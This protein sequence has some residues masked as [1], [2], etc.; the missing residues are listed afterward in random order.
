MMNKPERF[1]I[2]D[3]IFNSNQDPDHNAIE[4]PGYQPLTYRELRI[5]ILCVIKTLNAGGYHRN[6]RIAVIMP[7]GPEMAV[8][9]VSIMAGFTFIPLNP[10]Y[11]KKE[12]GSIFTRLKVKAIIVQNGYETGAREAATSVNIPII[13]VMP[14]HEKAGKFFLEPAPGQTARDA[15]FG[16]PSDIAHIFLTSGTTSE[17]KIVPLTQKQSFLARPRQIKPLNITSTDRCLHLVPYYHG[18]GIGLPLL[19]IW[20]AGGTV[21]CTKDFIAP[22]FFS[23][24]ESYRPT[25]YIAG[26]AHH[27]AILHDIK[28]RPPS[29]LKK[30]SL[31][32]ILTGSALLPAPVCRELEA[33]LGVPVV[34]HFASSETGTISLN[35]PPRRGSVGIPLV[36]HLA[37]IDEN[38]NGRE[39]GEPGEIIVKG[40]TV[41]SG[42]EDAPD[43]NK[44]AF[45]DGWFRTGDMGYLDNEGY[46]FLTGRKKEL[47]NKGGEKISPDEIDA[48]LR[49]HGGVKDAM[50]FPVPDRLLGED[51]A[52]L[53]VPADENV[54]EADLRAYLLDNLVHFKVPRRIYF[55]EEIPRNPAGKPL[56]HAGTERYS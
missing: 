37:I 20:L 22:D 19:C 33:F 52:A 31:R 5:Q 10:H 26:P 43:E 46:L 42:Y 6:D 17:S 8:I 54:T 1:T 29:D 49:S 36:E 16:T 51:V 45:I 50:T 11:K 25:F 15:E 27:Q 39:S 30:N 24:L 44:A 55:V 56:R 53:V 4:S 48:V 21:I 7:D 23:L 12:F 35:F 3:L 41:F 18:M 47:I 28:K 32:F 14:L 40:D 2:G 9:V 38:G 34:E 13:E